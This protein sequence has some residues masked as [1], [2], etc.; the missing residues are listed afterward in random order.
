MARGKMNV[1]GLINV[2]G[3]KP[4]L[5]QGRDDTPSLDLRDIKNG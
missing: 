1:L 5:S 3:T 2:L 4:G